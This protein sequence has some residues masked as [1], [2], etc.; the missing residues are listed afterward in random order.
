MEAYLQRLQRFD[1]ADVEIHA[2][3]PTEATIGALQSAIAGVIEEDLWVRAPLTDHTVKPVGG[4]R[5]LPH[6][7]APQGQ[8]AFTTGGGKPISIDD[9]PDGAEVPD[10]MLEGIVDHDGEIVEDVDGDTAL[11]AGD[12]PDL[13]EEILEYLDMEEAVDQKRQ[14]GV[15]ITDDE[16]NALRSLRAMLITG[17]TPPADDDEGPLIEAPAPDASPVG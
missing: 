9:L 13:S 2:D 12:T 11:D 8:E 3:S 7:P 17:L 4:P 1:Y 6:R 10:E 5:L 16:Y 15:M 14:A